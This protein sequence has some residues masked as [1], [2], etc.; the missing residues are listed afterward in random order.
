MAGVFLWGQSGYIGCGLYKMELNH[1]QPALQQFADHLE[2]IVL[3]NRA[4]RDDFKNRM[5][6][7]HL[8]ARQ[9]SLLE[10]FAS[11]TFAVLPKMLS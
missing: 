7:R 4:V 3:K 10:E 8:S 9:L 1:I 5:D 11:A 6:H 2:Q